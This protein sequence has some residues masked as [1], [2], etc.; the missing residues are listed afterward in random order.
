MEDMPSL[1]RRLTST[2]MSVSVAFPDKRM[3]GVASARAVPAGKRSPQRRIATKRMADTIVR[4]AAFMDYSA[5]MVY[6]V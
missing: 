3:M 6:T 4:T 2:V 1:P 5:T